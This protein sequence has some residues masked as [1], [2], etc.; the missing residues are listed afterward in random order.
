M[1]LTKS[2]TTILASQ[3]VGAAATVTGSGIDLT[4]GYGGEFVWKITNGASAPT[5]PPT[6]EIQV[7]PDNSNWYRKQLITGDTVANS[8]N[9]Q[10]L[11]CSVGTM[12][13]RAIFIGGATNGSTMA[14][15]L[16]Q[17]TSY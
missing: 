4:A 11:P 13:A 16:E 9:S 10:A 14:C 1:A 7:S 17:V 5:T 15:M 3:P 8:A 6:I 2:A 12:Y